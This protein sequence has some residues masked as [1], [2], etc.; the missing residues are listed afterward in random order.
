MKNFN[1]RGKTLPVLA[2]LTFSCFWSAVT[3]A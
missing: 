2:Q 3:F 1:A